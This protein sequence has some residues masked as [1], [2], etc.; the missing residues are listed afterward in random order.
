M[1]ELG[2]I[3][4]LLILVND[5][6][7]FLSH[8]LPIAQAATAEGYEVSVGH[9][10][11]G[12]VSPELVAQ[13]GFPT[14][15]VPMQ[16]GGTNPLQELRSLYSVWRLYRLLR[17]DLVHLVTI[18]PYLYGGLVARLAR[19]RGV[20]S[21]V[22]GLGSVFIRSDLR[23]RAFRAL[24]Y[25]I[26]RMAFGHPNQRVIV[27]NQDDAS[28]LINWGVLDSQKIRLLRGSG[29]DLTA[30]TQLDEP[31][32]VPTVCFA[33]RLLRDKGVYDFV[34]AARLLR[35]RG[36]EARFWLAGDADTKN[37][38]GLTESELQSLR[39]EG[40]VEVLG[41]QKDIPALYAKAH[42]V[43]LPSYREGLPKALVE[44]ASASRAVVTTD[45]PGCRD[46]IVP[47][48]SGLLVPVKS[49]E[50]LADALQ[51]LIEHPAERVAMGKAGRLLTEREFAIE[52][53]VQG[54]LEIY[55]EL[56]ES[57]P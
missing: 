45:V 47:N 36:I 31:D 46:A 38:T 6:S 32:G 4:K 7:Y 44:A 51:W 26:Y 9:G 8:R 40:V 56:L 11:L 17:P 13:L 41:Y 14:Y 2:G 35:E 10:E 23:S 29:V 19:V 3:I 48:E 37:P 16:R 12:G 54:H 42:I 25:P 22:A 49:P 53:I 15:F 30:F 33:A 39:D 50:K 28:V 52:K 20:V 21:A 24:L 18:K 27:Q 57:V 43:C 34:A 55:Q 5:L 1:F